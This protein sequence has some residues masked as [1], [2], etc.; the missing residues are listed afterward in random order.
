MKAHISVRLAQSSVRASHAPED[1][2]REE[3]KGGW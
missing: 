1:V 2:R 3:I